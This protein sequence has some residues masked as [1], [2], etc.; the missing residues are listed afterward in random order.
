MYIQR[1]LV[2][3]V[4]GT[5]VLSLALLWP[6]CSQD[7]LTIVQSSR[8]RIK[9]K[10]V[11]TR[12]RMVL[13]AKDGSESERLIDQYS[14]DSDKG[15]RTIIVFQRPASVSGTRFLTLENS[16]GNDDRW[17]FLPSLGKVR[18]IAS[19][20]G[21]GSFMG[22]DLSYDDISS[23]D[24]EVSLDRHTYIR[25]ETLN[26]RPCHV[27]ESVP[28]DSSYQYSK[29]IS[30]ID[31]ETLV[32][33]KIELFDK[34]GS[35]VKVLEV[36]ETKKVQNRITPTRTRMSTVA[37]KTSTTIIVDIIKYDEVIPEGVFTVDYLSTGRVK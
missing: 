18:R 9:A 22:T 30:W 20:E 28:N 16:K 27:I 6:V 36:L 31:E 14:S 4:C 33:W 7:A 10:T 21:S 17:I 8:D 13:A 24:R 26:G 34:K 2:K 25:Q 35:L 23:A 37:A 15:N 11:S 12:S 3:K 5:L 32:S 1:N 29:M 19:A